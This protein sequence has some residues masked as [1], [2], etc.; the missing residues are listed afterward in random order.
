MTSPTRP[1]SFCAGSRSFTSSSAPAEPPINLDS[2]ASVC[3]EDRLHEI[4][5]PDRETIMPEF[6]TV[7]YEKIAEHVLRITQNRPEVRNAQNLQLTYAAND[8]FDAAA[9]DDDIRVIIL[10]GAG[11]H[12]SAGHD[13]RAGAEN[14]GAFETVCTWGGFGAKGR[15]GMM[16]PEGEI[17]LGMSRRWPNI[18]KPTIPR[19]QGRVIPAGLCLAWAC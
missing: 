7:L 4:S 15:E 2:G 16:A 6:K 5:E 17:Y 11:P 19:G 14:I 3:Q 10:A 1:A 12:F 9:Q 18:P 13:L 8:A